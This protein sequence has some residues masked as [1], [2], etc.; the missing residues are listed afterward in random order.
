M[1]ISSSASSSSFGF[2]APQTVTPSGPHSLS[3]SH[4]LFL[5]PFSPPDPQ[6]LGSSPLLPLG[7]S[8][9]HAAFGSLA[10]QLS[11]SPNPQPRQLAPSFTPSAVTSLSPSAL[12]KPDSDSSDPLIL[13]SL[14]SKKSA[15]QPLGT[16]APQPRGYLEEDSEVDVAEI[17]DWEVI[18]GSE[19]EGD[20]G[21]ERLALF[22]A[23][24]LAGG[25]GLITGGG[26]V[27][28]AGAG[29]GAYASTCKGMVG[30]ISRSAG[31]TFVRTGTKA[32]KVVSKTSADLIAR[33]QDADLRDTALRI[34][35]TAKGIS[36]KSLEM[37]RHMVQRKQISAPQLPAPED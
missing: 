5:E 34:S 18:Q 19:V 9:N 35:E 3:P 13:G 2:S 22:G 31:R 6:S 11:S 16:L 28:I 23:A 32:T 30:D 36:S 4:P 24:A 37:A 29:A 17:D 1:P 25:I 15:P 33:A 12:H 20:E 27:A 26:V 8:P 14:S 21:Q 7:R 10:N